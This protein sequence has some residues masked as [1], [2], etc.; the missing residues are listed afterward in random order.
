MTVYPVV[1]YS[2]N[3][4]QNMKMAKF[5][6]ISTRGKHLQSCTSLD[7]TGHHEKMLS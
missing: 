6:S 1:L 4:I 3:D 7:K 2:E 5:L